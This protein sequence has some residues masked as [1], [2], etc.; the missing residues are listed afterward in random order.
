[1]SLVTVLVLIV[2]LIMLYAAV[3]GEK[4]T[5]LVKRALAGGQKNG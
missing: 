3:K 4:P 5:E 1:M 2:A